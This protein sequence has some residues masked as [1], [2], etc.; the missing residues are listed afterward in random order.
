MWGLSSPTK[1]QTGTALEGKVLTTGL[2]GKS[3]KLLL[4]CAWP[5]HH[6]ERQ[7]MVL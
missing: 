3:L 1:H 6:Q 4:F 5:E 7:A 2:P